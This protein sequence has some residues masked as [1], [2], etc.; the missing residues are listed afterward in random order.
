MS[1]GWARYE[2]THRVNENGRT[3]YIG[4]FKQDH[5]P[6]NWTVQ[7]VSFFAKHPIIGMRS[8]CASGEEPV[9]FA[10]KEIN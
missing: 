10:Y 8:I 7:R 9:T 1:W 6:H 2:N 3:L 4:Y 5:D